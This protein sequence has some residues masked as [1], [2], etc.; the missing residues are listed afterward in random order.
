VSEE[1][2]V[3]RVVRF[4]VVLS[5]NVPV[6]VN[7][8]V[9]P[10]AIRCTDGSMAMETRVALVTVN[11]VVPEML[12]VVVAVMAILPGAAEVANPWEPGALLTFATAGSEE[13][14]I[15]SVVRSCVVLSE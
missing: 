4:W 8:C 1:L 6:A 15:T 10:K 2:Q 3:T 14:Q 5:E 13:L 9:V 11:V 7:C 12:P